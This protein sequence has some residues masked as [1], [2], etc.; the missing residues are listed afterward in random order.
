MFHVL[1]IRN[2]GELVGQHGAILAARSSGETV[3]EK[4]KDDSAR[5]WAAAPGGHENSR[6]LY[7]SQTGLP[8]S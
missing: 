4:G 6:A 3:L 2:Y 5:C 7:I 8:S 1:F